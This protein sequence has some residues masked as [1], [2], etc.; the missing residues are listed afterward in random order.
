M[1]NNITYHDFSESSIDLKKRN[2]LI[3]YLNIYI[4]KKDLQMKPVIISI[5]RSLMKGDQISNKQ[6]SSIL[7]FLKREYEFR[8]WN[9]NEISMYFRFLIYNYDSELINKSVTPIKPKLPP[10]PEPTPPNDLTKF[11]GE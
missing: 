11:L 7:K 9:R 10:K 1:N 4:S 8:Y 6:F 5:R 2:Q 3:R